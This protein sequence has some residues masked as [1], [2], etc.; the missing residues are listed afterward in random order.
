MSWLIQ[1]FQ[2]EPFSHVYIRDN[3]V[4]Y[5]AIGAGVLKMSYDEFKAHNTV[6]H[7]FYLMFDDNTKAKLIDKLE[8]LLGT[9]YGYMQN[10]GIILV[11][12][13]N[14]WCGIRIGNPF[15]SGVNCSQYVYEALKTVIPYIKEMDP[16]T[17]RP[18]DVYDILKER[19]QH[20][21]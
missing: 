4:V 6:V 9:K 19:G 17:I 11:D 16:E 10:L 18:D 20:G 5:H 8:S 15:T 3:D 14:R 21:Q 13:L 7:E 2:G 12:G 1:A